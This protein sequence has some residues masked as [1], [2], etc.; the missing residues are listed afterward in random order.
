MVHG[1]SSP[2][3]TSAFHNPVRIRFGDS[4]LDG[5]ADLVAG[6][7][8]VLVTTPGMVNRGVA[9]R[10]E[11]ALGTSP[12]LTFTEIDP[13]PTIAG[14][15][16][17]FEQIHPAGADLLVALGGGSV[18][19]TAKAV[20]A[21]SAH[22]GDDGWL[23]AHLR[24]GVAYRTDVPPPAIIAIPT[25]AGTGSEVT[26]W[27]TIWD[28]RDGRKHSIA[29]PTLLPSDALLVPAFTRSLPADLTVT[30]A[31]DALSHAME[32]IWNRSANPVSD[33]LAIRA[34]SV[35][36]AAVE[37]AVNDGEDA[38]AR[39]AMLGASLAAGLAMSN[40]RTAVAHS[41]SYPLTS[42]LGVPHGI[43]CSVTLPEV[44]Q[45]VADSRPDRAGL[46]IAALGADDATSAA[47]VLHRLYGRIGADEQFRRHVPDVRSLAAVE[48]RLVTPGRADNLIVPFD[49]TTAIDLLRRATARALR[50]TDRPAPP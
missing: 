22:A 37:A 4:A 8:L 30:T 21:Q 16:A 29:H 3:P 24:D 5:L 6:R 46:I 28:E 36:P 20:A 12:V 32:A 43:A 41:M 10:V 9:A 15:T 17:A 11:D 25:T 1:L 48:P 35:I 18:M 33:A 34:I 19:D 13:N 38:S 7:R 47:A 40:T 39:E 23:S 2:I 42:I 50:S 26:W 45:L 31:L 49:E 44:L 27:G 14:T